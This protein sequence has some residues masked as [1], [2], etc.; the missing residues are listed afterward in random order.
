[1]EYL[2]LSV[3]RVAGFKVILGEF[4]DLSASDYQ[5][6]SGGLKHGSKDANSDELQCSRHN[7]DSGITPD[8]RE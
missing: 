2:N 7:D 3:C 1:V 4:N 8:L 5:S 6:V